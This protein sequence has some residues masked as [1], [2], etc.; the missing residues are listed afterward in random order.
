MTATT[1]SNER[2]LSDAVVFCAWRALVALLR[3]E[4][5]TE[6]VPV[7]EAHENIPGTR[8]TIFAT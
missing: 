5:V 6:R 7:T 4:R 3:I 1:T 8:Y 2:P